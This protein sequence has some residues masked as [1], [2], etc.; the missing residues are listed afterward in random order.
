MGGTRPSMTPPSPVP[1]RPR[2]WTPSITNFWLRH[3]RKRIVIMRR[4]W[5][6]RRDFALLVGLS[7]SPFRGLLVCL[8]VTVVHCAQTAVTVDID[9]ISFVYDSPVSPRSCRILAELHRLTAKPFLI[10]VLRSLT[11]YVLRPSPKWGSQM[12]PGP[13]SRRVLP[14]GEY[15]IILYRQVVSC[16]GC[17]MSFLPNYFEVLSLL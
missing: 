6:R 8:S 3:C 4:R 16:A 5:N 7:M 15:D 9:T 12:H 14:P 13:T 1:T 17:H 11:K 10:A 2:F